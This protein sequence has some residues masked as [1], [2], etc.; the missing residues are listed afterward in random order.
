MKDQEGREQAGS[1]WLSSDW[2]RRTRFMKATAIAFA[3]AGLLGV[4]GSAQSVFSPGNGVTLPTVVK[5][6][7]LIG[8]TAAVIGIECVVTEQGNIGTAT[9]A[10]SPDARFNDVA[11]RALRQWQFKPGTKDGKPVAVRIFVQIAIDKM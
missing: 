4:S 1:V 6:V 10:S 7:H 11:L 5:E 3:L 9:V 2:H 8:S